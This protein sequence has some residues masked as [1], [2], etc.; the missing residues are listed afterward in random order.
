MKIFAALES[1]LALNCSMHNLSFATETYED[2]LKGLLE[3][4]VIVYVDN[5]IDNK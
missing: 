4:T 3:Q 5:I 2:V 1:G